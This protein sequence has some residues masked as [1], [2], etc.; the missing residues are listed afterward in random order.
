M[1]NQRQICVLENP[2]INEGTERSV[3]E[4][5]ARR[6]VLLIVGRCW[7]DYKGRAS[8]TLEPGERI[9]VVKEDGSVLVH[10]PNSYEAVNWQP[11]GCI[12]QS[13]VRNGVLQIKAVRRK[14]AESLNIYFDQ[15]FLLFAM[16]M[17]DAGDF[18]LHASEEDMQKAV[19]LQPSLIET[20]FKPVSFE[21]K[22]EPG[23]VDVYGI[24]GDGKFVVVEI[25]RK[26]AGRNAVLQLSKYVRAVQNHANREVRG[27]LAAP[28][29]AKGTQRLL[30]MLKM[31]FRPLQPQICAEIIRESPNRKLAEFFETEA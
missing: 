22:V 26:T 2:E 16:K 3:K 11:P 19:L 25:K 15:I 20:G 27:I 10:R 30:D 23:F 12:F 17:R 29:I 13:K 24:D 8:S 7:V 14:P 4:T 6:K 18:S 1:S 9:V 31:T 21:K 5:L 28:N